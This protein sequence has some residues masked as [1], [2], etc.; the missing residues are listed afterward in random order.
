MSSVVF[1]HGGAPGLR[2][3]DVLT[4]R[5]ATDSRHLRDGCPICQARAAG[6][7]LPEDDLDPTLVYVTIQRIYAMLY[8]GG[9]PRGG[10]YRVQPLGPLLPS[11][12]PPATGS[13][14]V[15]AALIL[16]VLDPAVRLRPTDLRRILR[17]TRE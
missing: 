5:P 12:D 4:P 17:L 6:A 16:A 9:Y 3:G 11:P 1:Y 7:P 10:L 8:A 13:A 2:V 15:E 14:A